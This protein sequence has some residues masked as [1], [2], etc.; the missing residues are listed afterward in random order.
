MGTTIIQ[1]NANSLNAHSA[2]LKH[3]LSRVKILPDIICVQETFFKPDS[4]FKIVGYSVEQKSRRTSKGGGVATFIRDGIK[5]NRQPS[6]DSLEAVSI[7]IEIKQQRII[8]IN[9]IYI[10]PNSDINIDDLQEI[11]DKPNSLTCGDLNA[12]NTLW[13]AP[14]NDARG[15]IIGD[16]IETHDLTVLNSGGGT[17]IKQ[18]GSL[19]HLDV[20]IAKNNIAAKCNWH[21]HDEAWGSDHLPVFT[22]LNERPDFEE[23]SISKW[24]FKKADWESFRSQASLEITN[25]LISPS[26]DESVRKI[27]EKITQIASRCIPKSKGQQ[28]HKRTVPYWNEA[29]TA[30]VKNKEKARK[31][32]HKAKT[33]ESQQEYRMAKAKAQY[34]LKTSERE[35]WHSYCSTINSNTKLGSIWKM[36]KKMSGVRCSQNMSSIKEGSVTLTK[37]ADKANALAR[38]IATNS[39]D[40][41]YP[42]EFRC[43]RNEF[44]KEGKITPVDDKNDNPINETINFHELQRAIRQCKNQSS[45]GDDDIAYEMLK[46][47][48][49]NALQTILQI[50]NNIWLSGKL[51]SGWKHSIVLPFNKP[52]KDP[53]NPDSYRPIALTSALCKV[54][55]RIVT[56]RLDWFMEKNNLFNKN[57]TGFRKNKS[58][59]DQIMRL[60]SDIQNS[61]NSKEYTVGVF[62]DFSKAYDMLWKDGL[63]F[64]LKKLGISGHMYKYINDFLSD[65]SFQ[66]KVGNSL[67]NRLSLENG[68]PQG[69]VISPLL[70][71]IMIND[72][73]AP[74]EKSKT[75]IFADDSSIWKS[76]RDLDAITRSLQKNLNKIQAWCNQWGFI[77]S[78]EKT[79]AVIFTHKK[80]INKANLCI[81]DCPIAWKKEVKFLG[82]IFDERLNWGSHINYIADRC[83]KRLNLMRCLSGTSWG[84]S[85]TCLMI[86]YKCL[87][88]SVLDYGCS[89]YNNASDTIKDKL[90]KI[91][92]QALRICCG[93]MK[94]TAI[95]ALQVEC[96]EPPLAIR[97]QTLQ[98]KYCIKIKAIKNHPAAAILKTTGRKTKKPQISFASKVSEAPMTNSG[99]VLGPAI[100][101]IPPWHFNQPEFTLDTLNGVS[102][103]SPG[104]VIKQLVLEQLAKFDSGY[105]KIYTDGSKDH[106][107]RVG[108]AIYSADLKAERNFRLSDNISIYTA[109]LVAIH[110]ALRFIRD[111]K[112][113][114]AIILS[115]SL[116]ALQS[117]E[118]GK[119]KCRPNLILEQQELL[120]E[121]Y[122]A[123]GKIHFMWI[124][125]HTG[126]DGNEQADK[127]AKLALQKDNIEINVPL[128]L[129]EAYAEIEDISTLIWQNQWNNETT[130]RFYHEIEPIVSNK[131]KFSSSTRDKETLITRLRLGKCCLNNYLYKIGKHDTGLCSNCN[132]HETIEHFLLHCSKTKK[133]SDEL[134]SLCKKLNKPCILNTIL[135]N[136]RAC[137]IVYNFIK[138]EC[139]TRL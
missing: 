111:H 96:G 74:A 127:L 55:E 98:N 84:A 135:S 88:R 99:Q 20:S 13:G 65:R 28:N 30:A 54:M 8:I 125:G 91:Q 112:I 3:Y 58:T 103:D 37:N 107:N 95:S 41:N 29:C 128:E 83:K 78:K 136:Q 119:S 80:P 121:I 122:N 27:N 2:E 134:H 138:S 36:T 82:V 43:N 102:K 120:L 110:E 129:K 76:G 108:A 137:D 50:F 139:T 31:R 57:Q 71:L 124:P 39:S 69:S 100:S 94:C 33:L 23:S 115:D 7:A 114:K 90:D 25:E 86:I 49:N 123:G 22:T 133:L 18:D 19:S 40:N 85:K 52:G 60:Q 56:N 53:T 26:I 104:A 109:E 64:K 59:L 9:N 126:I 89:A 16:L 101:P 14:E 63:L 81:D 6:P 38:A 106:R 34:I 105:G 132:Q 42:R 21:V 130:G 75:A 4:K 47:L 79:I 97:R 24:L 113:T 68:T 48:P 67:S 131:I 17:Y 5:Y 15:K 92:A 11:L 62:L 116:S 44:Q 117:L 87:I 77:L 73:P 12:K 10:S 70:F 35:H 118:S 66:V 45:P 46:H 93:A 51:P 61:I 32:M 72:F 1:W